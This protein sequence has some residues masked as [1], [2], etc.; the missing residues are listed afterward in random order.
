MRKPGNLCVYLLVV[1]LFLS[2]SNLCLA[3]DNRLDVLQAMQDEIDRSKAKLKLDDYRKPYFISYQLYQRESHSL[4][5]KYGSVFRNMQNSNADLY[6]QVRVGSYDFDNFSGEETYG[7]FRMPAGLPVTNE[8]PTDGNLEAL[9]N[10]LWL[11]TDNGYREALNQFSQKRGDAV[12]EKPNEKLKSFSKEEPQKYIGDQVDFNFDDDSWGKILI[13]LSEIFRDYPEITQS[14]LSM[15]A[16]KGRR[17]YVN[18]EGSRI[19]DENTMF[20]ISVD[21]E[22]RA[23]DDMMLTNSRT[24]YARAESNFPALSEMKAEIKTMIAE[25]KALSKA[26]LIDPYTGPAILSPRAAGV[27]F[28]EAVGH[29][30]EG[31]RQNSNHE[32]RTFKGHL[33]KKILPEFLSLYDDPTIQEMADEK[34]NGYYLYDNEGVKAGKTELVKN[35]KLVSYLM[36]RTPIEGVAKSNGHGRSA[37]PVKPMARMGNLVLES[38]KSVS[39]KKLKKELIKLVKKQKKPYGI[40][41]LDMEGGSTNT[42]SYGYQAFKGIPRIAYRVFPDGREEMVRGVEM[43]GTPLSSINKITLTSKEIEV[44]NGYCG[45]E[46]GWVPVSAIAPAILLEELELQRKKEEKS[47]APILKSPFNGK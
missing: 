17:Y 29:R 42:S 43:V 41:I 12:F 18:T 3:T 21:A 10:S 31:E 19:L 16:G 8:A 25:L 20:I 44:F 5:V 15:Q 34:L 13:E 26:P 45:A 40:I 39:Y 14:E 11:L 32:G 7:S 38:N 22:A 37:G 9:R 6:V 24:F 1:I 36:S 33:N 30:L 4:V 23:E 28:H 35:G 27:L 47:R 46:S 2:G